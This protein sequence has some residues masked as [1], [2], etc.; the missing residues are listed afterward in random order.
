[1][2]LLSCLALLSA[3]RAQAQGYSTG[4]DVAPGVANAYGTGD[5][6]LPTRQIVSVS[7]TI[8]ANGDPADIYF[9]DL[10][11]RGR[12]PA[13][14]FP[15]VILLQGAQVAR[16]YYSQFAQELARYGFVVIV[17]DH[18]SSIFGS[19]LF[20][21]MNVITN[22]LAHLQAETTDVNSPLYGVVDTTRAGLSGH[23]F[24]SATALFALA[25]FCTFP[26]CDPAEGF[27]LPPEIEAAALVAGNSGAIDLDTMGIPT[28]LLIGELDTGLEDSQATYATLEPPRAFVLL[29]DANHYGLNDVDQPP[30]AQVR[31]GEAS[32]NT[33]QAITASRFAEWSGL[34]LRAYLYGDQQARRQVYESGGDANTV[35]IGVE[36]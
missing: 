13:R 9:P 31:E 23:S 22:A 32:Q 14:A 7:Q 4:I 17:P 12:S 10:P 2:L 1:M 29:S 11:A 27:Q 30:K 35:V 28:A 18:V 24:G 19:G 3:E 25:S 21:E 16:Q 15:P 34:F 5:K 8:A 20:S 26:F 33:P 6:L 36:K